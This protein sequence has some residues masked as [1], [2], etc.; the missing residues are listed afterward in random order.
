MKMELDMNCLESTTVTIPSREPSLLNI[1]PHYPRPNLPPHSLPNSTTAHNAFPSAATPESAIVSTP[2]KPTTQRIPLP[3]I[4]L[5]IAPTV[6]KIAAVPY[7]QSNRIFKASTLF[8]TTAQPRLLAAA[9]TSSYSHITIKIGKSFVL[10]LTSSAVLTEFGREYCGISPNRIRGERG[11][12][13]RKR[14][15]RWKERVERAQ[16]MRKKKYWK[17][18]GCCAR[19]GKLF[20]FRAVGMEGLEEVCFSMRAQVR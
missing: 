13:V 9:G 16:R 15:E 2:S 11:E 12:E 4:H 8:A 14:I 6:A 5:L 18:M 17:T 1:Y 20:S 3:T 10:E 7:P 19:R